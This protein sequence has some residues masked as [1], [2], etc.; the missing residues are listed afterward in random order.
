MIL[1]EITFQTFLNIQKLSEMFNKKNYSS[2]VN[3]QNI[4]QS[5]KISRIRWTNVDDDYILL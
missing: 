1:L 2:N 3:W 4:N 5:N